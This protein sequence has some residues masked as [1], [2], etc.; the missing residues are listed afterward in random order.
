[1]SE[2]DQPVVLAVGQE[3]VGAALVFAADEATRTGTRLHL[4]HVLHELTQGPTTTQ[5]VEADLVLAGR[6]LLTTIVDMADDLVVGRV[7]VTT[8][9]RSGR[10][11]PTLVHLTTEARMVVLQHRDLSATR[12]LVTR[13][14][15]SGVAARSR[16]PVATVPAGW[17]PRAPGA[18]AR[19]VVGVDEP[20]QSREVLRAAAAEAR[21]RRATLT[22]L[23][24]W[25]LEQPYGFVVITPEEDERLQRRATREIQVELTALADEL[26]GVPVN[27][28]ARHAHAADAL[29]AAGRES[30]LLVVGRHDPRLPLGS[31]L[32]P[33]V[34]AVLRDAES[35]VLLVDPRP[36]REPGLAP[37]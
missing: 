14:V 3:P 10:I 6:S 27:I 19:V 35:P 30:D 18:E 21:L 15:A 33:V 11:V 13:S 26:H 34:R 20:A 5:I 31:H 1:M 4:V 32:G 22:V 17:V 9:L 23:H 8:E 12:R 37:S 28:E 36:V 16:V 2:Q 25:S 7:P 29:V 24:T